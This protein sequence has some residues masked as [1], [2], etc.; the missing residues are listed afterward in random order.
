M[1]DRPTALVTGAS[2]GIGLATARLL[3]QEGH[4]LILVARREDRL[5]A[6]AESLRRSGSRVET[7]PADLA[8]SEGLRTVVDRARTGRVDLLVSNAGTGGYTALADLSPDDVDRLWRLNATAHITL[9]RAVLPAML[10]AGSGGIITVASLLAFSA[11]LD[12][13]FPRTLYVA[14]K[15]AV[16][17]FTRSLSGELRGTGVKATVVCP[18]LVDAEWSGGINHT[19]PRAMPAPDVAQALLIAHRHDETLCVPGIDNPETIQNWT[20]T[21]PTLLHRGNH[22]RLALRYRQPPVA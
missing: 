2:S 8:D 9:A 3:A 10:Q 19:D 16:V 4:D 6:E 5:T 13:G 17:A 20:D 14:A 18:G 22:A 7:L 21:E 12:M 1:T 11:G 15:S